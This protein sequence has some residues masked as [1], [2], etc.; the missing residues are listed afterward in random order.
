[1]RNCSC[2]KQIHE[3][4]IRCRSCEAKRK[5]AEGILFQTNFKG[6]LESRVKHCV[7][8]DKQLND[9]AY[10]RGDERCHKCAKQGKLN[11]FFGKKLTTSHKE[12]ISLN[13]ADVKGKNNPMFGKISHGKGSYYKNI[14]MR[15]TWEVKFAKWLDNHNIKWLYEPKTFDLGKTTY[16]PDF[17]VP[18]YATYIEIKGYWRPDAKNKF[19]LFKKLYS[20]EE[21]VILQKEKLIKL[22]VL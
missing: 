16:T 17:Y 18:I 6:G 19:N 8:C 13:H 3:T 20:R 21:I 4:S 5:H 7:D 12:K 14:W 15:S 2:G 1:M 11:N 22:G 10:Y 9:S